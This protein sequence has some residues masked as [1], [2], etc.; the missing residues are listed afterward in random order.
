MLFWLENTNIVPNSWFFIQLPNTYFQMRLRI[1]Q[2]QNICK[3]FLCICYINEVVSYGSMNHTHIIPSMQ[4]LL[5]YQAIS[6]NIKLLPSNNLASKLEYNKLK[7]QQLAFVDPDDSE[8]TRRLPREILLR[9]FSYLDV[10][11][12]C[13]CAQVRP[14]S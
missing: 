3:T 10:I 2:T 1:I 5:P 14:W 13:R 11:S 12:L 9:I 8:I 7:Y 4:T 6:G